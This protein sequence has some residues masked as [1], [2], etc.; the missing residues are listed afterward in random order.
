M[1]EEKKAKIE[2]ISKGIITAKKIITYTGKIYN[3]II[4][5]L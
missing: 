3:E 4:C 1:P 2:R 5:S